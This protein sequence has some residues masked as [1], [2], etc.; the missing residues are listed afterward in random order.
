MDEIDYL[1]KL[2]GVNEFKGYQE[3]NPVSTVEERS[4]QAAGIKE[5]EKAHGF[6]PGTPEWFDLWFNIVNNLN[7]TP[8]FRGRNK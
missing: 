6:L 2:A 7:Q 5:T 4:Q 8:T 1:K 3:Y